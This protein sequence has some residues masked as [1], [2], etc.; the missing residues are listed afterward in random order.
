VVTADNRHTGQ[1]GRDLPPGPTQRRNAALQGIRPIEWVAVVAVVTLTIALPFAYAGAV[2][3][4]WIPHN[5]DWAFSRVALEF[6]ATGQFGLLGA[7]QMTL[8][9]HVLWAQPFLWAL[10]PGLVALHVA[11]AVAGTLGIVASFLVFRRM[12]AGRNAL[13]GTACVA[14]LPGYGLL[15]QGFMTDT[16]AFAFE[17][18]C[19]ALGL[20]G[21]DRSGPGR[22]A[23]LVA[24]CL[25]GFAAFSVRQTALAGLAAVMI[26][27]LWQS[28]WVRRHFGAVALDALLGIQALAAMLVLSDWR[29]G[30]DHQDKP[31]SAVPTVGNL[32]EALA[33]I[34]TLALFVTPVLWLVI[35]GHVSLRR[36]RVVVAG[37]LSLLWLV[38]PLTGR[39]LIIGNM[40]TEWGA[41]NGVVG[42]SKDA[43]VPGPIWVVLEVLA[44]GG[45]AGLL[46]LGVPACLGRTRT[47]LAAIRDAPVVLLLSFTVLA[48]VAAIAPAARGAHVFDRYLLPAAVGLLAALS[49]RLRGVCLGPRA[50]SGSL[51]ILACLA[52]ITAAQ[53]VESIHFDHIRW[54][55]GE[56]AVRRGVPADRVDAGYEW[57]GYHAELPV[58]S[59]RSPAAATAPTWWYRFY[60]VDLPCEVV[61]ASPITDERYS[62]ARRLE[63]GPFDT[64]R[65]VLYRLIGGCPGGG[66]N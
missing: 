19:L 15:S 56:D 58:R 31:P 59:E 34:S 33:G 52:A 9:G 3:T 2:G 1:S 53:D 40:L 7:G 49:W 32:L 17:V 6:H 60:G 29:R 44:L 65:L 41:G 16:T 54:S 51:A 22:Y 39:E 61:M 47:K 48:T 30:L 12:S 21:L 35:R 4:L 42:G 25:V 10:G 36:P 57:T 11:N 26:S 20:A 45:L 55:A 5:D 38:L 14:L 8:I 13:L 37:L 46:A 28:V 23:Y 66:K 18:S 24:S 27:A 43:F 63:R 64:R 50:F 62:L